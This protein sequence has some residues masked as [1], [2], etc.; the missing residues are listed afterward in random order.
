[1]RLRMV[2]S[3]MISVM[4]GLYVCDNA[5]RERTAVDLSY[6]P[7]SIEYNTH[8]T[9]RSFLKTMPLFLTYP[10]DKRIHVVAVA[11]REGAAVGIV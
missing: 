11:A 10:W 4:I 6:T 7:N 5:A 1:M 2:E 8:G 3:D 9:G